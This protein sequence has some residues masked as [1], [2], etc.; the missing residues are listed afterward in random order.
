MNRSR[1]LAVVIL[2]PFTALSVYAVAAVGYIGIID[3]MRHS[4]AGWQVL[5]DLVIAL[6]LV[7]SWLIPEAR[8]TGRNPWPWVLV[9]LAAGSFGPLL[10]LLTSPSPVDGKQ[11]G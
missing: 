3:Y 4:P 7:L 2:V 1:M 9:T 6:M 5:A 11:I 8:R 10:F